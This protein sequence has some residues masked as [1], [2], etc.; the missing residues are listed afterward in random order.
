MIGIR[1]QFSHEGYLICPY[2]K[3][4]LFISD[5]VWNSAFMMEWNCRYADIF[6]KTKK[7]TFS[8]TDFTIFLKFEFV[9]FFCLF[10]ICIPI[11]QTFFVFCIYKILPFIY[12]LTTAIFLSES[13]KIKWPPFPE[14]IFSDVWRDSY[15]RWKEKHHNPRRINSSSLAEFLI[16]LTKTETN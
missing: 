7:H 5:R 3:Y 6:D 12:F 15:S 10:I 1:Q 16:K 4:L 9:S 2:R 14:H 8:K 13:N 11:Y